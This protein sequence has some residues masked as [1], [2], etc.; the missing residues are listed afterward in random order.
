MEPRQSSAVTGPSKIQSKSRT[1]H[2]TRKSSWT[3]A[4]IYEP[5]SPTRV[6]ATRRFFFGGSCA[7]SPT[8]GA[9][10][11]SVPLSLMLAAGFSSTLAV[12]VSGGSDRF[13]GTVGVGAGVCTGV[14]AGVG[15]AAGGRAADDTD[16][17]DIGVGTAPDVVS[18]TEL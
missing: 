3:W 12:G 6:N 2:D 9:R 5:T 4:S 7:F 14:C 15:T 18:E 8:S 1:V 10:T 16:G 11:G 13:A 17:V